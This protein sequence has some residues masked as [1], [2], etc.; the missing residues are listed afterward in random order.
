[1]IVS[2]VSAR[3]PRS[4]RGPLKGSLASRSST[5]AMTITYRMRARDKDVANV[6][7]SAGS[8][9][10]T[11][12]HRAHIV[13]GIGPSDHE[14]RA[15]LSFIFRR[16]RARGLGSS[17]AASRL[18]RSRRVASREGHLQFLRKLL[19]LLL[20][21]LPVLFLLRRSSLF[22]HLSSDQVKR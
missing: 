9:A 16:L 18:R 14:G 12:L 20:L 21:G 8:V 3:L 7:S 17:Y 19:V 15:G 2:V 10:P 22:G 1:M 6:A 13:L 4:A 11:A 5:S